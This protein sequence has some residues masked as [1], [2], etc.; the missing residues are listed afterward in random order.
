MSHHREASGAARDSSRRGVTLV[1]LLVVTAIVGLLL[2]LLLP[3]VQAVRRA[4]DRTVRLN[5]KRQRSL[6][7]QPPR[8]VPYEI[9]FVGNS[10]TYMNDVPGLI[11]ELAKAANKAEVRVTR[12]LKGGYELEWHWNEGVAAAAIEGKEF[13]FVVLQER[14]QKPCLAPENYRDFMVR[15]GR[16][17]REWGAI[18]VGYML[19]ERTDDPELCPLGQIVSSCEQSIRDIQNED[20]LADIAP[21]GPA[22]RAALDGRPGLQLISDDGNHSAP[23]GAY[24]AACVFH[25]L[26]HRESPE[27][28]PGTLAP[29]ALQP[30]PE[31]LP[32]AGTVSVPAE[33]AVFLQSIAWQT[34]ERWRQ[35]TKAWYLKTNGGR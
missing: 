23:T 3:A 29:A 12:V 30:N 18:P 16:L 8:K 6:G 31:G 24:L 2:A 26:I 21:V 25:S 7:E 15:F 19:W 4:S 32:D 9:L 11:A 28:L 14:S 27:G 22:W 33:D 10:H 35:K 5:W 17:A 13:D 34:A 1:E 20:G